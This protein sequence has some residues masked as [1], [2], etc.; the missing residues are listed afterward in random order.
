[1]VVSGNFAAID[2]G[3]NTF[4]LVIFKDTGGQPDI[5]LKRREAA[6]IGSGI[7]KRMITD[8]ALERGIAALLIFKQLIEEH[9][10]HR[11]YATATSA[12]RNAVNQMEVLKEIKSKTGIDIHIIDG[13]EEA[14][15]I[16][17]G[18]KSSIELGDKKGVIMDIGGGSVEFII[19]DQHKLHWKESFEIGGIRLIERYHQQDPI[20]AEQIKELRQYLDSALHNLYVACLKHKPEY[21]IGA[22]GS[23]D[24]L[25]DIKL[26]KKLSDDSI[27][28]SL[29][30][31][32]LIKNEI[33]SKNYEERVDIKGLIKMRAEMIVVGC[34]LIE[35]VIEQ[36]N[37]KSIQCSSSALK[38]GLMLRMIR[39]KRIL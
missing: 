34:L 12:F 36:G 7:E 16:Y 8:K 26:E 20:P 23:F 31:F 28:M 17:E 15:L 22:S 10:C 13:D 39:K 32:Q 2:L 25:Y 1:M 5:I 11:V 21:L 30:D 38:E 24:S 4:H 18:V 29:E 9:N 19:C 14:N 3:S 6:R 35:K 33:V 27:F 37:L